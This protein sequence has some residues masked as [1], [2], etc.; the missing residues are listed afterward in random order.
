MTD[1]KP[2]STGKQPRPER[3]EY[4][5]ITV[6]Q[7]STVPLFRQLEEQLRHA[8]WNGQIRPDER[9]PSTR[10]L[11]ESLGVARNTVIAAYE[12]LSVEGFILSEVGSGA[13]V[14]ANFPPQQYSWQHSVIEPAKGPSKKVTIS[15][16][17][18]GK[19]DISASTRQPKPFRANWPAMDDLSE[20]QKVLARQLRKP[21]QPLLQTVDPRGYLPLREAI[22][23]YLNISRGMNVDYRQIFVTAGAQQGVEL[24]A[25]V[26]VERGDTVCFE[27]PGY[28]PAA[29]VYAMAG[30]EI[31]YIPVDNDGLQVSV[32]ENTYSSVKMIYTTPSSHFPFGMTL[33]QQRRK[34]LLSWAQK[35][36][37]WVIEDDYNGEYRY[38]GRPLTS[39]HA[40]ADGENVIYIGSFS[41][42]LTPGLRLGYM[43]VPVEMVEPLA[44]ARWL[45]DRHSPMLDQAALAAFI[46]TGAFA[47]HL[48]KNRK[49]HRSRQQ[50]M[51][52]A[53]RRY[54]TGILTVSPM[55]AGLHLIGWLEPE[56]TE[57][58]LLAAANKAD[59][60]L[61]MVSKFCHR[62]QSQASVILGFASWTTEEIVKGMQALG[63]AYRHL[64]Y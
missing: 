20:W 49:L 57:E 9:L 8:I 55:D 10:R 6:Q 37:A 22:A 45:L 36:G 41:K 58:K 61:S 63:K 40:M 64:W 17:W 56:V 38:V 48:R 13:R 15:N 50:T 44:Q 28:I 29:L 46:N 30:A 33:S 26:L 34:A 24:L 52:A 32:L 39:L 4:E 11:A 27:D 47:R 31:G 19:V 3:F 43:V 60:E 42:L 53:A 18:L 54:L 12:Q 51:L 1:S 59:V 62:K 5:A 2:T 7:S 23:D 16:H 21:N 14:A 35:S 25:K